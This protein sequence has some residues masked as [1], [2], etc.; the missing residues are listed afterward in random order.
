MKACPKCAVLI[1]KIGG[2]NRMTC[3]CGHKFCWICLQDMPNYSH[4]CRP[5]TRERPNNQHELVFDLDYVENALKD[6]KDIGHDVIMQS[7]K[8]MD[9]FVHFFNLY[10]VHDHG[11]RFANNQQE[12]LQGRARDYTEIAGFS[13]GADADFIAA[14]NVTL[15]AARRVIK[16]TFAYAYEMGHDAQCRNEDEKEDENT[17]TVVSLFQSHQE[18]LAR[19][20]E[21]LSCLSE[22]PL[23][24]ED[25]LR[26]I[27]VVSSCIDFV[28]D[29]V[30]F[31]YFEPVS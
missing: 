15:V 26:L 14:A 27:D 9:R 6:S 1:Q 24:R 13:S 30:S 7:I 23:T 17:S 3:R 8:T 19:F 25:R 22:H 5:E 18:R 31:L 10:F 12:C 28:F 2:C 16:Y 29:E 21:E 11:Q 4:A 20:T